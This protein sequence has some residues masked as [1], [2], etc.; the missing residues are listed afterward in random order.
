MSVGGLVLAAGEGR[1]FG[2]PKALV[3]VDGERLV[4]RATRLLRDGGC[5]PV[6]V[7]SGAIPL[8]VDGA[9][10][11]HNAAWPTGMGSSV[12]AGLDALTGSAADAVVIALV[13][14]PWLGPESVRRLISAHGHGAVVAVATYS[15]Q[16][17][18]PVLLARSVWAAAADLARGDVGARAFIGAHPELVTP[19]DCT[20]TGR[21]DDVDRPVDLR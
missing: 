19:V 11:V 15:G 6:V 13:D 17:G 8:D 12:R 14:Q 16:R 4:D 3:E 1:R 5:V 18:N 10:V 21:P 7:V 9:D 2:R 20:D